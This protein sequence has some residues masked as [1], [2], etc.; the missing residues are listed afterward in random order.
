MFESRG[1]TTMSCR[2]QQT[3]V[4]FCLVLAP[5]LWGILVTD[6]Q[7]LGDAPPTVFIS[8]PQ[9]G[10][11]EQQGNTKVEQLFNPLTLESHF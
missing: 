4:A 11:P 1:R 3:L 5:S 10:S 7:A 9:G 8:Q 6:A 2:Q